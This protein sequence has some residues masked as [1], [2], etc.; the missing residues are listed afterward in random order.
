MKKIVFVI[1]AALIMTSC[2]THQRVV[3]RSWGWNY[4]SYWEYSP[5]WGWNRQVIVIPQRLPQ[6]QVIPP[7]TVR[8]RNRSTTP[9][10]PKR[11]TTPGR[12]SR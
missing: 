11:K 10:S 12:N 3:Y 5:Y 6:R 7:S 2:N 1:L 4:N 9:A 8:P